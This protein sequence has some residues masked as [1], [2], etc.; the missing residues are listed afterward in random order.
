MGIGGATLLT[1]SLFGLL[2][3]DDE[4]RLRGQCPA[5]RCP[6][7]LSSDVDAYESRKTVATVGL[8]TG[9]TLTATG[10][11]LYLTAP[12]SERSA[13]VGLVWHGRSAGL[14]GAF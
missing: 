9:A 12:R 6:G 2:A 4:A 5:M 11:V 1:G 7:N 13:R 10:V 8:L 14:W 3:L